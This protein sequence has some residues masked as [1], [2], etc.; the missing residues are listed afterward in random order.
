MDY[1]NN[2]TE[3][4]MMIWEVTPEKRN[5]NNEI[6]FNLLKKYKL[7][8]GDRILQ[9]LSGGKNSVYEIVEIKETRQ[10]SLEKMNYITCLT[11]WYIE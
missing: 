7:E 9:S 10:S 8:V 2:F 1:K 6:K 5:I 4:G 3:C 11:K